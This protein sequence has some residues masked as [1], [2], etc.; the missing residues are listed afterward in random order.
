[1][2]FFHVLLIYLLVAWVRWPPNYGKAVEMIDQGPCY[3]REVSLQ[4][5]LIIFVLCG[6]FWV[7]H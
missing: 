6:L 3:W 1:M 7:S 2:Q 4:C 5:K